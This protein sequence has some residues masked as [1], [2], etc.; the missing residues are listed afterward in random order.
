LSVYTSNIQDAA[1][2]IYFA[3]LC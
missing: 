3:D 1:K 2:M